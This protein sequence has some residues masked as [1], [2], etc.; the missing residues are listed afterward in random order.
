ME[1]ILWRIS[2]LIIRGLVRDRILHGILAVTFLFLFIP[3]ISTLSMRQ[4]TALSM[5]L[6]TSLVSFILLLIATFI[7]GTLL[8]KDFDRRYIISLASLPVPRSTYIFGKFLG[9]AA[10][11]LVVSC[12]LGGCACLVVYYTSVIYPPDRPIVWANLFLSLGMD[13]LKYIFLVCFALL[14]STV[15]TSFFLPV[16]GTISVFWLGS[17]SQEAFDYIQTDGGARMSELAKLLVKAFYYIIPNFSAFDFK[18]AAIYGLP[19]APSS[20]FM[21]LGYFTV[22]ASLILGFAVMIFSRRELQ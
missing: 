2:L 14:F 6:S 21:V 3:S 11:L 4:V 19:V 7:G 9:V 8:W 12:A 15:S 5:T 17:A 13:C 1:E 10:F 16:F 20:V 18:L 22:Y